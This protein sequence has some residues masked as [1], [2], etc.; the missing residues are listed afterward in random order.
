MNKDVAGQFIGRRVIARGETS[1]IFYGTLKE[2]EGKECLLHDAR[3]L[4]YWE[5]AA[6]IIE[7]AKSGVRYP[8]K[9]KFTVPI[10]WMALTDVVEILECEGDGIMSIERVKPWSAWKD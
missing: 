1:G 10:P 2:R 8:E 9:C 7:L 4:W 5:G 3:C 6:D